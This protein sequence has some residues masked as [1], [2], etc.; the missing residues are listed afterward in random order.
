M[1]M[2]LS[3]GRTF[4][5]GVA[6]G[7]VATVTMDAAMVLA[8]TLAPSAFASDRI[9]PEVIGRWAAGLCARPLAAR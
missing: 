7:V 1:K 8:A 9:G 5:A 2:P 3:S 4:A 6:G